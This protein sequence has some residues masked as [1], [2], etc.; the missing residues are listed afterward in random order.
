MF[1]L[2]NRDRMIEIDT[3]KEITEKVI[4]NHLHVANWD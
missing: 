1:L 3:K 2:R 4:K